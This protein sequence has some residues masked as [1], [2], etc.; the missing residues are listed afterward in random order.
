LLHERDLPTFTEREVE[1]AKRQGISLYEEVERIFA[2][3]YAY[4]RII[5]KDPQQIGIDASQKAFF[6]HLQ[7]VL[8]PHILEAGKRRLL[9]E[10]GLPAS[11]SWI[12]FFL[13]F[14]C[15]GLVVH[16]LGSWMGMLAYLSA[17]VIGGMYEEGRELWELQRAGYVGRQFFRRVG[18]LLF[19]F[20]GASGVAVLIQR[21]VEE[22]RFAL[23]GFLFGLMVSALPIMFF[24]RAWHE[25]H[26]RLEFLKQAGKLRPSERVGWGSVWR[27]YTLHPARKAALVIMGVVPF[28]S[29]L[30]FY[31]FPGQIHNG[32]LLIFLLLLEQL[33]RKLGIVLFSLWP[34]VTARGQ[35]RFF[36]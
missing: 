33:V 15:A 12:Q 26:Q 30:L 11:A 20:A 31:G 4:T 24:M 32:W 22:G 27:E 5:L 34:Y 6:L 36:V 3:R 16:A 25:G 17:F 1:G 9:A 21:W 19:F 7:E 23:A 14:F 13:L 28:L 35:G 29:A 18:V 10:V 2:Q 8:T